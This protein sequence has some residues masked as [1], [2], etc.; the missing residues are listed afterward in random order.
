VWKAC[1]GSNNSEVDVILL[2]VLNVVQ[3]GVRNFGDSVPNSFKSVTLKS[4]IMKES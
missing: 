4:K 1:W 2:L 3:V